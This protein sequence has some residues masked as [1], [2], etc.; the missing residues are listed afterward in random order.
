[1]AEKKSREQEYEEMTVE[2]LTQRFREAFFYTDEIDEM[3]YRELEQLQAALDKK[4][5]K[6]QPQSADA[7]WARFSKEHAQELKQ[8]TSGET[9]VKDAAKPGRYRT[10]LRTA[11][12]AAAAVVFLT[13]V[14]LAANSLGLWAWVPIWN[15]AAG[16]YEPA[17][18]EDSGE[19][20][21][22]AAL[23]ELGITEPLYPAKLPEGFVITES[24]ISEDPLVL[25][26]QYA[27]GKERLSITVTPT[28]GFRTAVYQ[29]GN[30]PMYEYRSGSKVHFI[31][32]VE[33]TITAI[34][35]SE[36]YVTTIS[37]DFS[38]AEMNAIIDSY[39]YEVS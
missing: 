2:E 37:G 14:A 18:Q 29:K 33:G 3:V 32:A 19:S 16:R 25:V 26:E 27:R 23:A 20:P 28:D 17:A 6:G 10:A 30:D 5:Q 21:I 39:N 9:R 36:N 24:H 11:L 12:V 4:Q 15:A 13:G 34:R 35:Y 31:F 8:R 1:M 22:P 7:F 38:L